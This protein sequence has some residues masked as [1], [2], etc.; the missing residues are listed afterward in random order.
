MSA[1][2]L[3]IP[4]IPPGLREAVPRA[5]LIPFVGRIEGEVMITGELK[6]KVEVEVGLFPVWGVRASGTM[7]SGGISNPLTYLLFRPVNDR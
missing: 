7:W 2:I 3:R 1:D 6:S 4:A 5:T